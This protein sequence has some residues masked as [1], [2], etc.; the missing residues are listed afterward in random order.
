MLA[1]L[2]KQI[3]S[4]LHEEFLFVEQLRGYKKRGERLDTQTLEEMLL[5]STTRFS[6][7]YIVIDALDECPLPNGQRGILLKSLGRILINAPTNLHMF[8]TSRKEQDIDKNLHA[9]SSASSLIEIDLLAHQQTLNHDICHY[10]ELK[11]A[12][13]DFDSWPNSVKEEVKQSLMEKADSM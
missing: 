6:S 1:S 3:C 11:L 8:V 13:V 9:F 10:I 12:S 5:A 7:V 2:I 4:Q